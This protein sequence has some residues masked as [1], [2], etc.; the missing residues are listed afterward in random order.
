MHD[1]HDMMMG[2]N[3]VCTPKMKWPIASFNLL[4]FTVINNYY[5]MYKWL[6]A[7]F[8]DNYDYTSMPSFI[9][10]LVKLH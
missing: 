8:P 7:F 4:S 5:V 10:G 6:H 1:M 9:Y 2:V 3:K